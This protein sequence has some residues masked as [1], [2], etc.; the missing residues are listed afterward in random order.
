MLYQEGE[1]F[2]ARR[3]ELLSGDK[4]KGDRVELP[5][6]VAYGKQLN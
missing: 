4:S 6:G 2:L 1:Q 5:K 3:G